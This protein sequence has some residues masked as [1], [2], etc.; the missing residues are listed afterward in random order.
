MADK[1]LDAFLKELGKSDDESET[2]KQAAG[3]HQNGEQSD[4]ESGEESDE[5]SELLPSYLTYAS[6]TDDFLNPTKNTPIALETDDDFLSFLNEE[7]NGLKTD[8]SSVS[9]GNIEAISQLWQTNGS[10]SEEQPDIDFEAL[11]EME[12][13]MEEILSGDESSWDLDSVKGFAHQVGH[14]PE[15]YRSKVWQHL[16]RVSTFV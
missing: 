1:D 15:R 11:G 7:S 16:L 9:H 14:F 5:N 12:A 3:I 13:K 6:Q 8:V 2:T 4:E 10:N